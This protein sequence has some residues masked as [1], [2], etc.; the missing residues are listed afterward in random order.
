MG[1]FPLSSQH[2]SSTHTHTHTHKRIP[3]L[4]TLL[5]ATSVACGKSG[6]DEGGDGDGE[7]GGDP[8]T[9]CDTCTNQ[10]LATFHCYDHALGGYIPLQGPEG[11]LRVCAA[12]VGT[13]INAC[14]AAADNLSIPYT[15]MAAQTI[16]CSLP[17]SFSCTGWDPSSY[18]NYNSG[19][20]EID[21]DFID[22]LIDDPNLLVECEA[23]LFFFDDTTGS[24]YVLNYVSSGDLYDELGLQDGD[25]PLALS[26]VTLDGWEGVADAFF[27][28]LNGRTEFR[29]SVERNSTVVFLNYEIV[30]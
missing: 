11:Y 26:G 30:P 8:P 22:D 27:Q 16:P 17:V 6:P 29:L 20:Y 21:Q 10:S 9:E 3:L 13:A 14:E 28:V 25:K 24:H 18:I 7:T 1:E 4:L 5:L 15:E 23:G 12:N 2:D 19:T